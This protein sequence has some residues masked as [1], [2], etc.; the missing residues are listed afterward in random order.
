MRGVC[1]REEEGEECAKEKRKER[2]VPK[3]R[4]RRRVCQREEEGNECAKEK[5]KGRRWPAGRR[6]ACL[7]DGQLAVITVRSTGSMTDTV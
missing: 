5:R 4:G 7:D 1:Q 2:S 6:T 3:R